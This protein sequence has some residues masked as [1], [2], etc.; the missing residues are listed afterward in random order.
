MKRLIL[1]IALPATCLLSLT[2]ARLPQNDGNSV[3]VTG[4][5]VVRTADNNVSVVFQLHVGSEVTAR[6]RSLIIRPVLRGSAGES[7]L[8]PIIVRGERGK[9]LAENRAMSAAGVN[10]E[11]RYITS[12]GSVLEYFA[13]VPWADWMIGSQ[14]YFAGLN[15]GKGPATEVN[16]GVV[17]DNLLFGESS[18]M[19]AS[20]ALL[21][22]TLTTTTEQSAAGQATAPAT[23]RPR[24]AATIGDELAARFAFVEPMAKY[25]AARDASSIDAVFDYNMP[26][27]FGTAATHQDDDVAKFVEMTRQGALY[28]QFNRGSDMMGRDLGANNAAL[29]ELISSIKLLLQNPDTRVAQIVVVGFSAPEGSADEKDT[30][31]LERA[32]VLRDFITGNSR[33]DPKII[34]IYNGSVD[35]VSLRALVA[36]SNMPEKYKVLDIIDN[37]PAW[38]NTQEKERMNYLMELNN[39]A[40][41]R[42]IREV[43]FPQLRQT[44]AYVKVYYENVQ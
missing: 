37:V 21:A 2:A 18:S 20:D 44:G 33:V 22:G 15:S 4:T 30:L 24:A 28:V 35:W 1:Y 40:A 23:A 34:G 39:G 11:G 41:F 9:A 32:G 31:A 27:F 25:I 42:H 12:N 3:S 38:G 29:V 14:L 16:I 7:E 6:N 26:L 5:E 43:F 10:A 13:S 17:A 8:P 36:E 19:Y